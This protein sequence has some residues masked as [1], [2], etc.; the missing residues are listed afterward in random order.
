MLKKK[1]LVVTKLRPSELRDSSRNL[2]RKTLKHVEKFLEALGVQYQ[3]LDRNH[4]KHPLQ[5]DLVL[6][7]G[8]DG[9]VLAASHFTF[10]PPILGINSAPTTSVGFYCKA[11]PSNFQEHILA[12]LEEKPKPKWIPRLEIWINGKRF[13]YFGLN[14]FL[15]ASQLQGDTARYW[16]RVGEKEEF[17]KSSG[18]WV[19]TGGGS[20]GAIH[21][22]GGKINSPFSQN[23]QYRVRE[24]LS[25]P[26]LTYR[27][28]HGYV[29]PSQKLTI[30]SDM[31]Q[32]MIFV[33]GAKLHQRVRKE[34]RIVIQGNV[35]PLKI[36]L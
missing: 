10:Q 19:S 28:L 1:V 3:I 4:I 30:I 35:K 16:I 32:G 31:T 23:L 33:D 17:Q 12:A 36:F 26:R 21:S 5:A 9:T 8:G 18:L 11:D 13:P 29:P 20:T 2:H 6:A 25:Y 22:A 27:L 34:S 14:D 15:F 24:P 7:V